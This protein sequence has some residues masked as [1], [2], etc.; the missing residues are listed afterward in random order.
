MYCDVL[1]G[2]AGLFNSSQAKK[3]PSEPPVSVLN[4]K[5]AVQG[6][7]TFCLVT[8]QPT[9]YQAFALVVMVGRESLI[10]SLLLDVTN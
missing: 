4:G 2:R 1:S 8:K 5:N 9:T 10:D 7:L 6:L 3:S